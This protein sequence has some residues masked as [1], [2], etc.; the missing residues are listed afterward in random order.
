MNKRILLVVGDKF[1]SYVAHKEAVTVSELLALLSMSKTRSNTS[2]RTVLVPGQ[3]IGD[4]SRQALL[5]AAASSQNVSDFDFSLWHNL[6]ERASPV[7]SHK[8]NSRNVLVSVPRQV[9]SNVFE[10]DVMIDEDCELMTDHMSGQHMQGM[11]LME[12][13]RQ[14]MIVV[15]ETH[16]MP[17]YDIDY[18]FIADSLSVNYSNYGFPVTAI[19]RIT[20]TKIETD[21]AKL[22]KF[23]STADVMQCGHS[24]AEFT[25]ALS[26]VE[27][28]RMSK[29]ERILGVKTH[30]QFL[31]S[32]AGNLSNQSGLVGGASR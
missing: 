6:P 25:M 19:T 32:V 4:E 26:A 15:I 1:A 29:Q 22:L 3:G 9:A 7:H 24:V 12:A 5:R 27:K 28:N 21:D 16:L 11:V 14:A 23:A 30:R 13:A 8:T 2:D 18:S 17:D 10:L 31:A 20:F